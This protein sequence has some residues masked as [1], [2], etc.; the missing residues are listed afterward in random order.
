MPDIESRKIAHGPLVHKNCDMSIRVYH[1]SL[2]FSTMHTVPMILS[3][4]VSLE[5]DWHASVLGS[6][7]SQPAPIKDLKLQWRTKNKVF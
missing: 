5:T 3:C 7:H 4:P 2:F 1:Q 6:F